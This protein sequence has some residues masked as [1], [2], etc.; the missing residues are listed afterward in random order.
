MPNEENAGAATNPNP[1]ANPST[2]INVAFDANMGIERY[3][4]LYRYSQIINR[5]FSARD[6]GVREILRSKNRELFQEGSYNFKNATVSSIQNAIWNC[7]DELG[8]AGIKKHQFK[9]IADWAMRTSTNGV[10]PDTDR[11]DQMRAEYID[12]KMGDRN[13]SH[14]QLAQKKQTM[15]EAKKKRR[16]ATGKLALT[17]LGVL[18]AVGLAGGLTAGFGYGLYVAI[19]SALTMTFGLSTGLAIGAVALGLGFGWPII[20]GCARLIKAAY[21]KFKGAF[22]NRVA[23]AKAYR[24]AKRQYKS[25]RAKGLG[26]EYQLNADNVYESASA[27]PGRD[28]SQG[29]GRARQGVNVST[30]D[31]GLNIPDLQ[32][33]TA[34]ADME[35]QVQNYPN[36]NN[37]VGRRDTRPPIREMRPEEGLNMGNAS[38]TD[39]PELDERT[40]SRDWSSPTFESTTNDVTATYNNSS[41]PGT[42]TTSTIPVQN[43]NAPERPKKSEP[44]K[45]TKAEPEKPKQTKVS[46]SASND[47]TAT[48]S[49]ASEPGT[50]TTSTIPVQNFEPEQPKR[51]EPNKPA[52]T[53][54]INE[55]AENG[56]HIRVTD[57][58]RAAKTVNVQA[59]ESENGYADANRDVIEYAR[60]MESEGSKRKVNYNIMGRNVPVTPQTTKEQ[61]DGSVKDIKVFNETHEATKNS[62][63]FNK[64]GNLKTAGKKEHLVEFADT[65]ADRYV[66]AYGRDLPE[67]E[68]AAMRREARVKGLK[69]AR[70]FGYIERDRDSQAYKTADRTIKRLEAEAKQDANAEAENAAA[71]TKPSEAEA[72]KKE[73][74]SNVANSQI[75]ALKKNI[76]DAEKD[77]GAFKQVV[78]NAGYGTEKLSA[79]E[80]IQ[81]RIEELQKEIKETE[82]FLKLANS[83]EI[84][85]NDGPSEIETRA[86]SSLLEADQKEL[87]ELQSKSARVQELEENIKNAKERLALENDE[88]LYEGDGPSL[89]ASQMIQNQIDEYERQLGEIVGSSRPEPNSEVQYAMK[90]AEEIE[91][92]IANKRRELAELEE[93]AAAEKQEQAMENASV[94]VAEGPEFTYSTTYGVVPNAPRKQ[95]KPKKE[96]PSATYSTSNGAT[97]NVKIDPAKTRPVREPEKKDEPE[98]IEYQEIANEPEEEF[99]EKDVKK[100]IKR[101]NKEVAAIKSRIVR[102]IMKELKNNPD[103]DVQAEVANNVAKFGLGDA[104]VKELMDEIAEKQ[105]KREKREQKIEGAKKAVKGAASK[106]ASG[107]KTAAK[108][109]ASGTK[110]AAKAV[111]SGVRNAAVSVAD[112]A[113]DIA[114][115]PKSFIKGSVRRAKL[116]KTV[117]QFTKDNRTRSKYSLAE[118]WLA[119]EIASHYIIGKDEYSQAE[120][121]IKTIVD[122]AAQIVP[123]LE[124]EDREKIPQNIIVDYFN[125][126]RKDKDIN[127][128]SRPRGIEDFKKI[129]TK[130]CGRDFGASLQTAADDV[131][132]KIDKVNENKANENKAEPENDKDSKKPAKHEEEREM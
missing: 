97:P 121:P 33:Q 113:K 132:A 112:L 65:Y 30:N 56:S 71:E 86:K 126:I 57:R 61:L 87:K 47:I 98:T 62:E 89:I 93:K 4:W 94:S 46:E 85:E 120:D 13:E 69:L 88:S 96:E 67:S 26:I 59:V 51:S 92:D 24:E 90:R 103:L 74:K 17:S 1:P 102:A 34:T 109:V 32:N 117:E 75:E 105:G 19:S 79:G 111:A 6:V 31:R 122:I 110:T 70:D 14:E 42:Y 114:A 48:Y 60:R 37:E 49:N 131:K 8:L 95:A 55:S 52:K 123:Q 15:K 78:E 80:T 5:I 77:L 127:E 22:K 27:Y 12:R 119:A 38:H 100:I 129:I 35:E 2:S 118:I 104:A 10:A 28:L 63:M 36:P 106:V 115:G 91:R 40:L 68:K 66:E 3:T 7:R 16:G 43:F 58:N 11:V 25:E 72:E 107:T 73:S 101:A 53:E 20:K 124:P 99:D 84:Y 44:K 23:D 76:A 54:P 83:D 82:D 116:G 41:E 128:A 50:Y 125:D 9:Q 18:G 108:A 29:F 45:Q 21:E 64:N 39:E 81:R 130:V